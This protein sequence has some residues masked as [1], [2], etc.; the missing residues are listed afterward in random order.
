MSQTAHR[1]WSAL[2]VAFTSSPLGYVAA[3]AACNEE[4]KLAIMCIHYLVP[5]NL[6]YYTKDHFPDANVR[7]HIN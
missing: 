5:T 2:E 3:A 6:F 4:R 1:K 7:K